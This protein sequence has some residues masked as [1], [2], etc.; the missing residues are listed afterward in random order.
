MPLERRAAP[1][2]HIMGWDGSDWQRLPVESSINP[3]LRVGIYEGANE[4]EVEASGSDGKANT[5]NQ[6]VTG[7]MRYGFN[8]STW[9]RWRNNTNVTVLPSATRTVSGDSAEQT[10]CNARGVYICLDITAVSGTFAAGEGLRI[11]VRI[12]DATAIKYKAIMT[13]LGPYTTT[14]TYWALIYPGVTDTAGQIEVENDVP[15][16]RTWLVRY[17]ITGTT[18]SFTFSVGASYII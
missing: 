5:I 9:D 11:Q 3:N 4:A 15:L 10:N 6:L 17:E 18:P 12:K 14:G 7:A 8:E 1:R 2:S 16:S 13:W